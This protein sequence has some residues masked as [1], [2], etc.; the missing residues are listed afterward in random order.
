MKLKDKIQSDIDNYK[1]LGQFEVWWQNPRRT[2][3]LKV[4]QGHALTFSHNDDLLLALLRKHDSTSYS[5]WR[6][7]SAYQLMR[8][9][10]LEDREYEKWKMD[11]WNPSDENGP[12]RP[13]KIPH[14][15]YH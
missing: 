11:D 1:D 10:F 7:E 2:N 14:K 13:S 9:M 15:I 3:T 8:Y 4:G 5:N 12:H 6:V